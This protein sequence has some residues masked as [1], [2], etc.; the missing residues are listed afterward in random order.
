MRIWTAKV[1]SAVPQ[2]RSESR[3]LLSVQ[4]VVPV[5]SEGAKATPTQRVDVTMMVLLPDE[6]LQL[7]TVWLEGATGWSAL[8]TVTLVVSAVRAKERIEGTTVA[9]APELTVRSSGAPSV[10]DQE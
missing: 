4:L 7:A 3:T 2:R 1:L 10:P 8:V 5:G 9:A 6:V